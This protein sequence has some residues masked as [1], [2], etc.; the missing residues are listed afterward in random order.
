[1]KTEQIRSRGRPRTLDR[2]RALETALH[3]FWR[4]GYE[5]TSIA[6]LTRAMGT[7]PPSLY[8]A[9]GTKEQLYREALDRY[10]SAYGALAQKA[11]EEEPT[12]YSAFTRLLADA[13][14]F[15]SEGAERRGCMLVSGVLACADEHNALAAHV[16][17]QRRSVIDALKQR[18]DRAAADGEIHYEVDTYGLASFF[19]AVVQGIAIQA[20]DGATSTALN[21]I[22]QFAMCAWPGTVSARQAPPNKDQVRPAR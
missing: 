14:R 1:M 17:A 13:V 6:D 7:T 2:E 19:S 8:T 9:F 18:L 10:V 15:Y 11:F 16:S 5:G 3:L 20:R 21:E 12:A 22:A 4:H